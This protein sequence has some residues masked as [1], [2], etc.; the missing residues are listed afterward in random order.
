M[1]LSKNA[2]DTYI[3][4]KD[5]IV[6]DIRCN[7]TGEPTLDFLA[8]ICGFNK[9]MFADIYNELKSKGFILFVENIGFKLIL[10]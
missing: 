3:T 9:I 10:K 7:V 4:L 6:D 5:Y 8:H 1:K 2:L